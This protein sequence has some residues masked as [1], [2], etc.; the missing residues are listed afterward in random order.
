MRGRRFHHDHHGVRIPAGVLLL[1]LSLGAGGCADRAAESGGGEAVPGSAVDAQEARE[2]RVIVLGIDGLD[3]LI[4]EEMIE[5]GR[6]EHFAGLASGR[7]PRRLATSIP[8]QSP[9]AWSSFITGLDP[10]GHR[11]FDFLR[12]DRRTLAIGESTTA[13]EEPLRLFGVPLWGGGH[14]NLREGK[15]FWQCLEGQAV[16]AT[17]FRVPANFPPVAGNARTFSGMGT[18]DLRGTNGTFT[19]YTDRPPSNGGEITGGEVVKV[20]VAEHHVVTSRLEGP[21]NPY[22]DGRPVAVPLAVYVDPERP[23]A[24]IDIDG[25]RRVLAEGEWSDWIRVRFPLLPAVGASGIVRFYLK[26][27]RPDFRLY[28]SPVNIDPADP[29]LPIATPSGAARELCDAAG[30]FYTQGMAEDTK[31]LQWGVL[32][33]E[34]FLDQLEDVLA[35]RIVLLEH[36]LRRFRNRTGCLFFYVSSVDQGSHVLWRARDPAHPAHRADFSER[37][38]GSIDR[39]YLEMD[40]ILGRVL[41]EVDGRTTLIVMSDH[42]FAPF[43]RAAHLNNRLAEEGFLALYEPEAPQGKRLADDVDWLRTS[44]YAVGFNGVYLNLAGR[45]PRGRVT[46]RD[47]EGVLDEIEQSLLAWRDPENGKRVVQRVYRPEAVYSG[48]YVDEAPDL[49]VGYSRGYRASWETPLGRFGPSSLED[50]R[51][52]WSGDHLMAAEEV[53]GVILANRP[54]REGEL[55]LED[56]PATILDVFGVSRPDAMRGRSVLVER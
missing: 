32:D 4:L 1:V 30:A 43:Y 37:V 9:V 35:E 8:P 11:I 56:V 28:A 12:H 49:I 14:V 15:A 25:E 6:L 31:A 47:K 18:P 19:Y 41:E 54:L 24:R 36:E 13:Q 7:P 48:P 46:A 53:P 10:G 34:E 55:R 17:V 5:A 16:A 44:A 33:D 50:N 40:R 22:R 51:G 3:P 20:E 42:G 23:L 39:L 26:E 2:T 21:P 29:V 38:R 45:S 27:V 52:V